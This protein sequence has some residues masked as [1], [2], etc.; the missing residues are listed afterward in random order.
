MYFGISRNL[1]KKSI[2]YTGTNKENN[3]TINFKRDIKDGKPIYQTSFIIKSKDGEVKSSEVNLEINK[4]F[5]ENGYLQTDLF[6]QWVKKQIE[7]IES[8]KD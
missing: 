6:F 8:K 1:L 3:Q 5:N 7:N 4:V 2:L